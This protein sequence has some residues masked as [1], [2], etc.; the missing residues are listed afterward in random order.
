M[1]RVLIAALLLSVTTF[2]AAHAGGNPVVVMKTSKGNIK[3]ELFADKA[4]ITVENFLAYAK[5]GHYNGTIF[6]RVIPNF[7]IQ[8]GGFSADMVQKSTKAPIKNEATNGVKNTNGTLAMARTSDPHSAS[9]QFFINTKDND[10]LDHKDNGRGFGYAVF[11]KVIDGM[12]VVA[13]IEKVK[14]GSRGGHQD[15]PIDAVVIE[16][17]TIAE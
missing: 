1:G 3:I 13:E 10:F 2:A 16:S 14:T 5:D 9:A 17:V 7:M 6:H 15:V 11:G 8:G 4:P 12:D